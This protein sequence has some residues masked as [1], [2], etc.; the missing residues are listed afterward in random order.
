MFDSTDNITDEKHPS[1]I[2][3]RFYLPEDPS[4][5]II[6]TNRDASVKN[7]S[8]LTAIG[9]SKRHTQHEKMAELTSITMAGVLELLFKISN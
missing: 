2:D 4:I 1:D 5:H 9:V 7:I 6:V 3:L 8:W